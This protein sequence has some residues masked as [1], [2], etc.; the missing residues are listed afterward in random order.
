MLIF[1]EHLYLFFSTFREIE[2]PTGG[3]QRVKKKTY[4]FSSGFRFVSIR[5]HLSNLSLPFLLVLVS[6]SNVHSIR[7]ASNLT[8]TVRFRSLSTRFEGTNRRRGLAV[9]VRHAFRRCSLPS[10]INRDC[11]H[12]CGQFIAP[13]ISHR[14]IAR[15]FLAFVR[16]QDVTCAGERERGSFTFAGNRVLDSRIDRKSRV[17]RFFTV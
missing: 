11:F 8:Q 3:T 5:N 7:F 9:N 14:A 12:P 16:T 13:L 1:F 10:T 6:F 4:K 17:H 2:K 15:V